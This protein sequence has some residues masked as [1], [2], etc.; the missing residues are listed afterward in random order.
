MEKD[1]KYYVSKI[2]KLE[3]TTYG[4]VKTCASLLG[5][6]IL[7]SLVLLGKTFIPNTTI[8]VNE[9]YAMLGLSASSLLCGITGAITAKK[10]QDTECEMQ[11]K[12]RKGNKQNVE[13]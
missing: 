2:A 4:L 5:A 3:K 8:S 12:Y 13:R 7:S 9:I 6:T 10:I 1:K 11:M